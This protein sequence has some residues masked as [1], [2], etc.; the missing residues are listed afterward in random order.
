[1]EILF[2]TD[3]INTVYESIP[4]YHLELLERAGVQVIWTNLDALRDSN[5]LYSKPWRLF[6]KPWGLGAGHA[7]ANP[8]GDGRISIRSTLKLLN[9]KANHRK[10]IASEKSLLVGSANPHTASSLHWNTAL[11]VDGA[12]MDLICR[13][14]SAIL[15][16]S[17]RDTFAPANRMAANPTNR[18][19]NLE[20]LTESKIKDRV[21][22]ELDRA[23]TGAR[24]DLC[25][26]YFSHRE[27]LAAFERAQQRGCALRVILD[28]NKDAFGRIKN[29]I[30]NRQSADRLVRSGIPVR[31]ADTKGEQCH[32]KMLYIQENT[33]SVLILGS[34][35]Y[36]RRNLDDLNA[37]CNLAFIAPHDDEAMTC[38]RET[39]N[40]WWGNPDGAT[41]TVDYA[42]YADT[43][44]YRKWVA[45]W[46]ETSGL[47]TF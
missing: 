6:I 25:M 27:V 4:S 7:V 40:R 12:G 11:R 10:L 18:L 16:L 32:V 41:F 17:G 9:F 33:R 35:N 23:P 43:L 8:F 28:P 36:T 24:I 42:V 13:A 22:A 21:V 3:P 30:P 44:W 5:P 46:K 29:G 39:F 1:M 47:S 15:R 20:L 37:E 31:W 14:E 2:I 45:W 26:F 34:C 38:A 19:P